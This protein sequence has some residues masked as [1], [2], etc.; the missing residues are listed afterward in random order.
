VLGHGVGSGLVDREES[1]GGAPV[2]G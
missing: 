1:L 2:P